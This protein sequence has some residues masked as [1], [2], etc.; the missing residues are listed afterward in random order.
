MVKFCCL[1]QRGI[2][3]RQYSTICLFSSAPPVRRGT[4]QWSCHFYLCHT[5]VLYAVVSSDCIR[6]HVCMFTSYPSLSYQGTNYFICFSCLRTYQQSK[7]HTVAARQQHYW[8]VA[9][10]C[11]ICTLLP[12]KAIRYCVFFLTYSRT[13][14]QKS[15]RFEIPFYLQYIICSSITA[16][17]I[18]LHNVLIYFCVQLRDKLLH[19]GM[20]LSCGAP[21]K[22][23]QS[24]G[25]I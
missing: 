15:N 2:K 12:M 18:L 11:V 16:S 14:I 10:T 22:S 17:I 9:K 4:K 1:L 20:Y 24:K 21:K 13:H 3:Q 5:G 19:N 7:C 23:K 25:V 8:P 6:V